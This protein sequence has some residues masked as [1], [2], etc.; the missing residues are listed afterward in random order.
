MVIPS[1]PPPALALL[2]RPLCRAHCHILPRRLK[3]CNPII[4]CCNRYRPIT[5]LHRFVRPN[6]HYFY[7]SDD[8]FF[9]LSFFFVSFMSHLSLLDN[10]LW[11][12]VHDDHVQQ[13]Y[14]PFT[15]IRLLTCVPGVLYCTLG[16]FILLDFT[17]IEMDIH[18]H[19]RKN[20]S[21]LFAS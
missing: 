18:K 9:S 15:R 3:N 19:K 14:P 10:R 21:F 11:R 8:V 20:R 16:S 6:H 5:S 12:F 4:G 17:K 7:V 2:F 1:L 13:F